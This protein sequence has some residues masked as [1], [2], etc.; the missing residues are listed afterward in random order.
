M[1]NNSVTSQLTQ[2]NLGRDVMEFELR[3]IVCQ[4]PTLIKLDTPV[5][6]QIFSKHLTSIRASK[7]NLK[8]TQETQFKHAQI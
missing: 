2:A 6:H 8:Y 5:L 4:N 7:I 3:T 1:E